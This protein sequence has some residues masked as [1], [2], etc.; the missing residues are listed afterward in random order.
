MKETTVAIHTLGCKANQYD[1]GVMEALLKARGFKRVDFQEV[2]DIYIINTCTVTDGADMDSRNLIG[3]ARRRNPEAFTVVTGCYAQTKPQE[4]AAVPGVDLVL[5]NGEKSRLLDFLELGRPER[6]R[7]QVEDIFMHDELES[8]EMASYSKNTRAFLKIQDGCNQFCSFCI[9]PYARGKNRSLP[10]AKVLAELQKLSEHGFKEAV[11]TGIHIGTY[12]HDLEPRTSLIELLRAIETARP[13]HRVRVSSIDPEEVD[14]KML[15]LFAGSRT[16]CPHFH[17]PL[18]A[19]DD[20]TLKMMRR[21]YTREDFLGLCEKIQRL[22]PRACIGTD[23]I[24]GFPYESEA[25]FER[26]FELLRDAQVHY[27]HVFPFS[28]KRGTR[29]AA[30]L[31]QTPPGAKKARAVRLRTLSDE[32]SARFR[33]AFAGTDVEVILERPGDSCHN[34]ENLETAWTGFSEN[35]LPVRLDLR[36]GFRGKLVRCRLELESGGTLAGKVNSSRA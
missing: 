4:V 13:I 10:V 8:C 28:P 36:D 3:R 14:D 24:V 35:Y 12:G 33:Q 21:R 29:A 34:G 17:I 15:E 32:K 19:G 16:L 23:V 2:A 1:G 5:G 26:T 9:I 25:R 27:F 31:G 6:T 30:M 7:I 11:L 18:Q 22:M 20:E